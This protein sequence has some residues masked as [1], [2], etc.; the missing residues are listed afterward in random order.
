M[1]DPYPTH[2]KRHRWWAPWR[3][4]CRCGMDA[5]PCAAERARRAVSE[6]AAR[7]AAVTYTAGRQY[8]QQWRDVERRRWSGR[9]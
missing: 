4:Y 7:A 9:A 3:T 2:G 5:Y 1:R 6:R 8:A